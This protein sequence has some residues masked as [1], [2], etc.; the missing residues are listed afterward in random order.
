MCLTPGLLNFTS[1]L[2]VA[3][4][5]IAF[6]CLASAVYA[7]N[8]YC[9]RE[10]D[11]LHPTK[12][13]RPI[14]GGQIAPVTALGFSAAL[15]AIGAPLG[16]WLGQDVGGL[17]VAYLLLNIAYSFRL[18][19]EAILDVLIVASCYIIRVIAGSRI[20]GIDATPWLIIFTGLAALFIAFAKRRDD[21][22][23][24]LTCNHRPSLAGYNQAF[25]DTAIAIT[26]GALVAIY[27]VYAAAADTAERYE[28]TKMFYTIPFVLAGALRYLQA[29]MVE[30]QSGEPTRF[31]V[32]DRFLIVCSI[33]WLITLFAVIHHWV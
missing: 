2:R 7:L 22:S 18:K 21:V 26:L 6:S 17:C 8:D 31:V 25:L 11:K 10:A 30:E 14:A 15:T 9:D 27:C 32:R 3:L 1:T 24:A 23:K 4:G 19:H 29:T 20:V 33:G 5:F 13:S 12:R 28:T 16:F